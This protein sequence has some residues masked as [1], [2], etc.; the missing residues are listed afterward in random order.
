MKEVI[1]DNKKMLKFFLEKEDIVKEAKEM[2]DKHE[3]EMKEYE[4]HN[5]SLV[6]KVGKIDT[7]LKPMIQKEISKIVMGEYDELQ[8]VYQRDGEI[9]FE[10]LTPDTVK[11]EY[12]AKMKAKKEKE[13]KK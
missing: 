4:E 1:L 5:K 2:E 8:R 13:N 7:K 11:E 9:V 12:I 6:N 10:I 3:K